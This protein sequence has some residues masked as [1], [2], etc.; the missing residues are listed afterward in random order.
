MSDKTTNITGVIIEHHVPDEAFKD[1]IGQTMGNW[2]KQYGLVK[3]TVREHHNHDLVPLELELDY[4]SLE[5]DTLWNGTFDYRAVVRGGP[6][7]RIG[8]RV[9]GQLVLRSHSEY[10]WGDMHVA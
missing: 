6:E 9:N 10:A 2:L 8:Q 3:V 1:Y 4:I 7:D 5:P